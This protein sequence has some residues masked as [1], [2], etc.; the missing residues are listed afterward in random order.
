MAVLQLIPE[1]LKTELLPP[2]FSRLKATLEVVCLR[3]RCD[4]Y[5]LES[6]V[7]LVS[8]EPHLDFVYLLVK[9]RLKTS[10]L[11]YK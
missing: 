4:R 5:G 1:Q 7:V 8:L 3:I 2:N 10:L 6:Y 11:Q 9:E